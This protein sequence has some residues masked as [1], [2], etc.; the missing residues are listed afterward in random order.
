[1]IP[2]TVDPAGVRVRWLLVGAWNPDVSVAVPAVVAC[3]PSP[4]GVLVGRRRDDLV[5]PCWWTDAYYDLGVRDAC[6]EEESTDG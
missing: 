6:G 1:M 2:V 4:I 3:M 5:R